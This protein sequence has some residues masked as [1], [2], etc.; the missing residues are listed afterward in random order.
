MGPDVS[1][2]PPALRIH[3]EKPRDKVSRPEPTNEQIAESGEKD[4]NRFVASY[5][6]RFVYVVS[7]LAAPLISYIL[8]KVRQANAHEDVLHSTSSQRSYDGRDYINICSP[9]E[10]KSGLVQVILIKYFCA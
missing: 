9:V 7:I 1:R 5:G 4:N 6:I 2:K 3:D 8:Y 10:L